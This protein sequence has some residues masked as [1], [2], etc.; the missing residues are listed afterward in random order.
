MGLHGIVR[1]INKVCALK[2]DYKNTKKIQ[3]YERQKELRAT[4]M[5]QILK[6]KYPPFLR[7]VAKQNNNLTTD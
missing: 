7:N 4:R 1:D 3:K 5:K 6:R 2:N